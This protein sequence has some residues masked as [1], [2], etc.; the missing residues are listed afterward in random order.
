MQ[1][2]AGGVSCDE[3]A[4]AL[5]EDVDERIPK[6]GIALREV[7]NEISGGSSYRPMK[8][9]QSAQEK[10]LQPTKASH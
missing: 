1:E 7:N 10:L 4:A 8:T 9:R 5:M 2:N 6:D 3:I